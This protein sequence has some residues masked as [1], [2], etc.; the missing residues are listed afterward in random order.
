MLTG[1]AGVLMLILKAWLGRCD[2]VLSWPC[3]YCSVCDR[4]VKSGR[5]ERNPAPAFY[6]TARSLAYLLSTVLRLSSSASCAMIKDHAVKSDLVERMHLN[7]LWDPLTQGRG[8]SIFHSFKST[9]RLCALL[10]SR[11][12]LYLTWVPFYR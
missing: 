11:Q 6:S 10:V 7:M 1:V 2:C 5:H 8:C 12:S 9:H 4:H 3:S